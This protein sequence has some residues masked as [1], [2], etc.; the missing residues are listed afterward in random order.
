MVD[1]ILLLVLIIC[2][3]TDIKSRKILNIFTLPTILF[4]IGFHIYFTGLDGFL[5]SGIGLLVGFIL[6]FIPFLMGGIGAGDVKLLT[7][8][9]ALK[10]SSFVFYSFLFAAIIGGAIALVIMI[11][12]KELKSFFKR[13]V[14]S[15]LFIKTD[16]G[17]LLLEKKDIAPTIPYG[18]PIAIGTLCMFLMGEVL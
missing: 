17:S 15:I 3:V 2:V 12:R 6:L 10:G 11:K 9:G 4:G 13:L 8:I 16:Q 5:Y 1:I 14:F 7:A 18:V